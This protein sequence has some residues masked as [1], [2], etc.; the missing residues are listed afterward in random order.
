[1]DASNIFPDSSAFEAGDDTRKTKI[2]FSTKVFKIFYIELTFEQVFILLEFELDF[3]GD[4]DILKSLFYI[5]IQGCL[6]K[7]F[8]TAG[9]VKSEKHYLLPPLS[10]LNEQEVRMLIEQE[11]YFVLHAPRQTGKTSTM[12]ELAKVLNK[13]GKYHALYI[14]VEVAQ[15]ARGDY[16]KALPMIARELSTRRR[17][18]LP[19][20]KEFDQLFEDVKKDTP[21]GNLLNELLSRWCAILDKPLV[22]FIDEIDSLVGDSLISVLRQI[23]SG[24]THRPRFFPQS[25]CLFGVR[26]VRDYRIWSEEQ[27]SMVLGGSAFNIKAESLKMGEF[28]EEQVRD[29]YLQHTTETGQKFDDDAIEYAFEQTQGQP[30]LVNALAYQACFKDCTDRSKPITKK[31]MQE[32]KEIL[33]LRRDTHLDVLIDRLQEPRIRN[34]VDAIISGDATDL[35]VPIDDLQYVRDLGL[36]KQKR[37]EIANPIY[38]EVIPRELVYTKQ[39]AI[40]QE[41]LWYLKEDGTIDMHKMLESWT[42]FFRENSEIWL[43]KF[44]YKE[45]GPHLLMMA[46]LQRIINGGGDIHREYALGRKRVD[47]L[48]T[49]PKEGKQKVVVELKLN[50]GPKAYADGLRQT[51]EYMDVSSATEGHLIIFDRKS[52]KSWDEKIYQKDEVVDDTTIHVWGM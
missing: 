36:L 3:T 29:L 9:P 50:Y 37:Y 23:R 11:K 18:Q 16:E 43:G 46:F 41:Q 33:I 10:R 2:I 45:S 21:V 13:E 14:N 52:E 24:Y 49:W 28:T 39:E 44:S 42:E 27:G 20:Q 47:L 8:N 22:L 31:I 32:A 5:E 35:N 12:L 6:M 40:L 17:E 19:S 25:V 51:K 30:W 4:F 38:Q 26:D 7:F 15:A 1:L 48:L 34:I